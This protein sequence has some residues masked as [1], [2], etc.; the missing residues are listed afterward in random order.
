M[1]TDKMSINERLAYLRVMQERY[2]KAN[3]KDKAALLSQM[4]DVC[5]Y[6]RK[7]LIARMNS[8]DLSRHKRRRERSR[9]YGME[10]EEAVRL[11]ADALDWICAERLQ[12][13]L[14]RM[15]QHLARHDH[16]TLTPELLAQLEKISVSTVRR[17]L[18]RSARPAGA[19]PHVR[20]GRRPDLAVQSLV[21]VHVI[22]W[23]EPE[24]G[25]FEADLV[26]H[27]SAPDQEGPFVCTLNL[28]DILT[29]WSE[30]FAIL[31][32]ESATLWKALQAF[33]ERCPIPV[34]EVHCDNGPEFLN[35]A[36]ISQFGAQMQ[37]SQLTRGRPGFKNDNRFVEQKNSS[38]IRAYLGRLALH[39]A[40]QRALLDQIYLNMGCYYNLFQ[41]VLRQT[42][43][44][45]A[46]GSDGVCRIVRTQ[47]RAATPLERLLRAK[48]PLPQELAERLLALY[49]DTDPLALKRLIHRQL[50]ELA[51]L[52]QQD[53]GREVITFR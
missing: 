13:C 5:G 9:T 32:Y 43:R 30:R 53:E 25:H 52:A 22:P 2:L 26:H 45:I 20:R 4:E 48:P 3:R 24:P 49:H 19:L 35:Y 28:V 16:L 15:A 12:P 27:R 1:A 36:L 41:P 47:D 40:E 46:R 39:T 44:Q 8:P 33:K 18:Q 37:E 50:G 51:R 29:G 34:R 23:Q 11:V 17:I 10:V 7:Y 14:A 42:S 6:H 31:G 38:I 21:P